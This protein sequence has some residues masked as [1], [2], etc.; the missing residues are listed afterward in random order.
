MHN[1]HFSTSR[2]DFIKTSAVLAAG[3]LLT[4]PAFAEQGAAPSMP[5]SPICVFSKHLH[6]LNIADMATAV[7]EMGYD[8]ID[9]TVRKGGHIEPGLAA[10][11]LPGAVATIRKAGLE[12]PM[13]ATDIFDAADPLTT[14]ILKTA[15]ALGIR[16]YRTGYLDFD[17]NDGVAASLPRH[18]KTLTDLAV[19]NQRYGIH[20]AYQNHSGN[21]LG[22]SVWDL[23]EVL[24]DIDPRWLGV[25]YDIKH[26]TGEGGYSWVNGLDLVKNHARC[27]DLKDFH[28][29]KKDRWQHKLVP[30]G[31]G[32]VDFEQFF[33]LAKRYQLS[34]PMSIHFEYPLGGAE[35]GKK[36]LSIAK[37]DVFSAMERDLNTLKKMLSNV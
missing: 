17:R 7:A 12:V 9:L 19:L 18:R 29:E 28:W 27:F 23:W 35:T 14:S 13:I 30:L 33:D 2:R 20:G 24:K 8:G 34:G 25:Q 5:A 6:W 26:A 37:E 32:M 3:S 31:E 10:K 1:N 36:Q 11:E 15:G 4:N 21:K 16:F 22:S